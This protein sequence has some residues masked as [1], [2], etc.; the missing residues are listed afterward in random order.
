MLKYCDQKRKKKTKPKAS[1][2]N[3]VVEA[4]KWQQDADLRQAV[5]KWQPGNANYYSEPQNGK[6]TT[7][8]LDATDKENLFAAYR[9]EQKKTKLQDT[10]YPG[11]SI[12]KSNNAW[13]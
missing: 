2:R 13:A 5:N 4:A 9:A 8:Y 6:R 3:F 11:L 12:L 10:Q 7:R 1:S